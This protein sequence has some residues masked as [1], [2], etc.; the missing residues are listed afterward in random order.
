M[1]FCVPIIASDT[2]EAIRKMDEAAGVAD[3]LE[4]RLDLMGSFDIPGIVN[5]AERPVLMTYR[6]LKEGGNGNDPPEAVAGHLISAIESGADF[7]DVE[8]SMP[9]DLRDGI[10]AIGRESKI[11]VSTHVTTWT[12]SRQELIKV[13]LDSIAAGGDIIKIVTMARSWEDNLRVLE[14][15]ER[16]KNDGVKIIS[17]CMG[18]LG[19]MSRVFSVLMGGYLTFA[20]LGQGQESANGQI[21]IDKMRE[22]TGFFSP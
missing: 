8:L 21:P 17:F 9:K 4:V 22:I 2:K 18:P 5:A 19:M 15:V 20:S 3:L 1:M 10:I 11:I 12:P 14:L 13:F 16:A 6:S 7:V